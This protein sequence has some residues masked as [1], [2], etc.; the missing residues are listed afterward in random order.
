VERIRELDGVRGLAVLLV[1]V[2]NTDI[3][4]SLHLGF[5]AAN[6]WMGVDLFF[7]LSGF[8]ITRIL[9]NSRNSTRYYRSFYAKRCLRI[10]PLY[11]AAL[12]FMFVLLPAMHPSAAH[13]V[14]SP[15]SSPW[16]SYLLFLQNYLVPV[17]TQAAGLLGVTWSLVVEEQFYAVWPLV[18][19]MCSE[20]QLRNIAISVISIS[21][22][23]RLGLSHWG[24]NIYSNPV[25]RLDGLMAGALLALLARSRGE[26]LKRHP[27]A[28]WIVLFI[29]VPLAL[30]ADT[31]HARWIAFSFVVA[32][33]SAIVFL[34]LYSAHKWVRTALSTPFLVYTGTIS[35]GIYILEKIP[36]DVIRTTRLG[37]HPLL[38]FLAAV[39]M[40]YCLATLSWNVLEK[41]FLKLKAAFSGTDGSVG[42]R[43]ASP[44]GA[45]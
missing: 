18:V 15:R 33:C 42:D 19:R 13:E 26:S 9:L 2:H 12:F 34:A 17:P 32:F 20:A 21:P 5:I 27:N 45:A 36:L 41:P 35:Y 16:W 37:G 8:L 7:V 28:A 1:L 3:Y 10:W 43:D 25:C 39:A 22:L 23:L 31:L 38:A 40:T 11:Y 24:V 4:P 14:F 30:V 44:A 29:A 6:G